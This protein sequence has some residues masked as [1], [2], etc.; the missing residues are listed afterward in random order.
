ME[1]TA[2][3]HNEPFKNSEW[4]GSESSK[5][6]EEGWLAL[7]MSIGS[8]LGDLVAA[9]DPETISKV[10]FEEKLYTT[11]YHNRVVLMGDGEE[12]TPFLYH[13][14]VLILIVNLSLCLY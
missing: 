3:E 7:E 5:A 11:W 8:T 13:F 1:S 9:T 2:F 12:F 10:Y 6:I 4:V 14:F